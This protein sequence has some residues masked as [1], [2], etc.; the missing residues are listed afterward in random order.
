MLLTNFWFF[1]NGE[2]FVGGKVVLWE[3]EKE[4]WR[5]VEKGKGFIDGSFE[6]FET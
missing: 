6:R 1:V 3:S 4:I 2:E 5:K